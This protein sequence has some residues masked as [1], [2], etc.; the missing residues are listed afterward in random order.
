[1]NDE[2]KPGYSELMEERN[3][4]LIKMVNHILEDIDSSN[5]KYGCSLNSLVYRIR[6]C[7]DEWGISEV[8]VPEMLNTA[9]I[10]KVLIED[11]YI[12]KDPGSWCRYDCQLTG[13][14]RIIGISKKQRVDGGTYLM[15]SRLA[16]NMV[17]DS[18]RSGRFLVE[19][20]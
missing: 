10:Y 3:K 16:V 17:M 6:R 4:L 1:M 12:T 13:E 14:G 9:A 19:D 2:D 18:I 7:I 15:L 11:G 5:Y 8:I 20:E